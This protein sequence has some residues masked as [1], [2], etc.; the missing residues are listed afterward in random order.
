MPA[1][2][3][4]QFLGQFEKIC[5]AAGLKVTQQRL[6]I[7]REL[8]ESHDHPSAE[9]L[10][11]RLASRLPTLSLDTVYRTLATFEQ[12]KVVQRLETK[13]SQA[14][15]EAMTTRHHHFLC[16]QC[17]KA[18][19]F[20]WPDFDAIGLPAGLSSIG[21]IESTNVVIDG[22]CTGCLARQTKDSAA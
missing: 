6:E 13:E 21:A 17:G 2:D 7:Y 10:H 1:H 14:R 9:T 12:C 3:F 5:K 19:D 20:I 8:L 11:K 16:T 15:F 18:V 4:Q 22:Q